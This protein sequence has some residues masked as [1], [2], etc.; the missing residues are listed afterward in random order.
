MKIPI[1]MTAGI[2]IHNQG[3]AIAARATAL[4]SPVGVLAEIIMSMK[5]K[6][7]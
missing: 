7:E 4:R 3:M 5:V 6:G 2:I 1:I